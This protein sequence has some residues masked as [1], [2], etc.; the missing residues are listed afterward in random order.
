MKSYQDRLI[1]FQADLSKLIKQHSIEPIATV[2]RL[3]SGDQ[4]VIT[5]LDLE[6]DEMLAKYGRIRKDP[7]PSS[8]GSGNPPIVN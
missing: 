7:K 6:S 8:D 2:V 5:L 3:P 4:A 1:D